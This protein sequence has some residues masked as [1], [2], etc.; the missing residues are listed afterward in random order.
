MWSKKTNGPTIR[1]WAWG[2]TRP[3][4][5]PPRSFRRWSMTTSIMIVDTPKERL[6]SAGAYHQLLRRLERLVPRGVGVASFCE[7]NSRRPS[8]VEEPVVDVD[9]AIVGVPYDVV[10]D[11]VEDDLG[12]PE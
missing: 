6:S 1:R 12:M 5:N 11:L 2:R 7:Q 4:S 9:Q 8:C 10:E 3:T